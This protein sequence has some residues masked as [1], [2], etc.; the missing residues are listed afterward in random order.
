MLR[1]F[2]DSLSFIYFI[3]AVS[4]LLKN[5]KLLKYSLFQ[6]AVGTIMFIIAFSIIFA[7]GMNWYDGF[8]SEWI[9]P[10]AEW[11]MT[12]IYYSLLIPFFLFL[13]ILSF[14]LIMILSQIFNAPLNTILSEKVEEIYTGKKFESGLS[15]FA[16]IRKDIF[17]EVKK[18]L[19]FVILLIIPLP[20]LFIPMAGGFVYAFI[21]AIILMFTLTY[22]FLDYPMERDIPD[23][24]SR[25]KLLL[26]RPGIWLGYG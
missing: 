26:K 15:F 13:V 17:Y 12:A 3:K 21:S 18:A 9:L 25:R 5:K 20:L 2:K 6:I 24:K 10:E 8:A 4:F 1:Y 16:Q 11:Y 22:D 23:L 14:F 19:F 7:D